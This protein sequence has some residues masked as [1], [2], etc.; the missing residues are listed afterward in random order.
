MSEVYDVC[1]IG[2]GPGGYVAA[3]RSAQL[4]LKTAIIEREWLGGVCLNVG[5]IPS[6]AMITAGHFLHKMQHDGPEMGFTVGKVDF[7]MK[8]LKTW[9]QSVCDK[10]SGGVNQLLKGNKVDIIMGVADFKNSGE[11]TVETKEGAKSVKAKN[12]IVATGSRPIDIPGFQ[13]DETDVVTSTG[14]LDLEEV[15]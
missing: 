9:K 8:Q 6:K 13:A 3:I 1:V 10:M 15:A 4:G 7:N 5:C 14:A 2:S 11:I 12:F